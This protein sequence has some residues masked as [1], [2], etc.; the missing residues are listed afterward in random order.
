[1][2]YQVEVLDLYE[3]VILQFQRLHILLSFMP[4]LLIC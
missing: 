1:M 4:L 3:V 2:I